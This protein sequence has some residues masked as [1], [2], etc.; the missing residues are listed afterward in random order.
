MWSKL[1]E[2]QGYW[3]RIVGLADLLRRKINL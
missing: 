2:P 3:V 1:L